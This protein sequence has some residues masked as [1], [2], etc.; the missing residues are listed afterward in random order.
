[1]HE[2]EAPWRRRD[3][4]LAGAAATLAARGAMLRADDGPAP[5]RRLFVCSGGVLSEAPDFRMLRYI[6]SL[7]GKPD[8]IVYFV[9][10]AEGDAPDAIVAW[11]E[12][13]N[14]LPCRPRHLRLFGPTGDAHELRPQLLSAD[15]VFVLGGNT[16][17]MLAVWR[18]QEIDAILRTAW[19]RG[20]VL[21]GE[22]AGMNCW[23]EQSLTDSRPER[24]TALDCLGWFPGSAC[25]HYHDPPR[26][27]VYHRLLAADELRAGLA[28]DDGA[29][30]LFEGEKLT[31]VVTVDAGATAY[32]VRR[33]GKRVVEE[34]LKADLLPP[35][36][37]R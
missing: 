27:E 32:H 29:G 1:M 34:K 31:R 5:K 21:A 30:V 13:A 16:M 14:T 15:A 18:A 24:M 20:V 23:F 7:T 37:L 28:C 36:T 11:Y 26:R 19:E 25:P 22:S 9:P 8:P 17:N 2:V 12:A 3:F 33:D 35:L 6:L 4:L 10:T